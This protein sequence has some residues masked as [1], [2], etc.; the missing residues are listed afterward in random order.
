MRVPGKSNN[1]SLF[2]PARASPL[3]ISAQPSPD[4]RSALHLP[5]CQGF[6]EGV[7]PEPPSRGKQAIFEGLYGNQALMGH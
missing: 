4:G 7:T 3:R 6:V 1:R 5:D 2:S